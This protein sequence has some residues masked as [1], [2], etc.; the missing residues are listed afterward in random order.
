MKLLLLLT[1][2]FF[3]CTN[4]YKYY[5]TPVYYSEPK[6]ISWT[7]T[8]IKSMYV[9]TTA[10]SNCTLFMDNIVVDSCVNMTSCGFSPEFNQP[11]HQHTYIIEISSD[12]PNDKS[13]DYFIAK[14]AYNNLLCVD[15]I[16]LVLAACVCIAIVLLFGFCCM[17]RQ[18]EINRQQRLQQE[19]TLLL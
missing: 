5:T 19:R 1:I 12:M 9:E 2:L 13:D 16:I 4:A 10:I 6:N 11:C 17:Y 3:V 7:S 14:I 18:R 15:Y 8:G